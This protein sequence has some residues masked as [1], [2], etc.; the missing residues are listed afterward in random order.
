MLNTPIG[1]TLACTFTSAII[2]PYGL[3][4]C[5]YSID[6]FHRLA[7]PGPAYRYPK[8][9]IEWEAAVQA[10]VDRGIDIEQMP[11][12]IARPVG[13][14]VHLSDGNHRV[15]AFRRVGLTHIYTLL[16]VDRDP[17]LRGKWRLE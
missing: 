2:D 1:E 7:G 9:S 11:P 6:A 10:I 13:T 12:V 3:D 14:T 8:N 4:R 17:I 15:D 16:W 5:S